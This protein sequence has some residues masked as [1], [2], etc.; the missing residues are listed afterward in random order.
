[1]N[2][3]KKVTRKEISL[4][5]GTYAKYN[6]GSI[7]GQWVNLMEYQTLNEFLE[8][9]AEIHKDEQ[10]PEFMFQDSEN[11]P[12]L[13]YSECSANDIYKVIE[14]L[15]DNDVKADA[16]FAYIGNVGLEYGFQSFEDAYQGEYDSE[17]DFTYEIVEQTMEIPQNIAYYFDY[18]KF[19]RDL[20]MSD[21]NYI[22]GFVFRNI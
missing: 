8:H 6:N 9:C 14:F 4:Y 2:T 19:N 1:M 16:F 5:V 18:E 7:G 15:N 13:L 10:D 17:I 3:S 22:D 11:I 12:P 21:Y 20:F